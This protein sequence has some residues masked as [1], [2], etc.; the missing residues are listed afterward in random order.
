MCASKTKLSG[1]SSCEDVIEQFPTNAEA[2]RGTTAIVTGAS[3]GI[4]EEAAYHL[5]TLGAF[6]I[7]AVRNI[8]KGQAAIDK[9]KERAGPQVEMKM[10][11]MKL[12]TSDLE[13]VHAFAESFKRESTGLPP[14]K[15]LLNNAGIASYP[16]SEKLV[17]KQNHDLIFDTNHLGHWVLTNQLL[18]ILRENA[19]SRIVIVSSGSHELP[20]VSSKTLC[21]VEALEKAIVEPKSSSSFISTMKTYGDSKLL[22]VLHGEL[23]RREGNNGITVASLHPGALITTSIADNNGAFSRFMFKHVISWFTKSVNQGASTTMYCLLAESEAVAGKYHSHCHAVKTSKLVTPEAASVM[24][25]LSGK[26]SKI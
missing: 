20:S 24:W 25:E 4:G 12:D 7:Y 21:S 22:N 18:P 8:K 2:V 19:P 10:M 23:Q 1:W 5:A 15:Y 26:V 3:A 13:S 17:S 14:L 11:V 9:A 16:S 6:V